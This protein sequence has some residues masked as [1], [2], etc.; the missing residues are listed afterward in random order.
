MEPLTQE[1]ERYLVERVREAL[2]HD[3]RVTALDIRVTIKDGKIFLAGCVTTP[4]RREAITDVVRDL[5]PGYEV[6]NHT[7]VGAYPEPDCEEH[8]P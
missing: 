6:H 2:A 3:P 5:L 7:T 8:V 4:E 1:P